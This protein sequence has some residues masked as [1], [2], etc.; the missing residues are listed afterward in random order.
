MSMTLF[1]IGSM[2]RLA[3]LLG[4]SKTHLRE[5]A[6]AAPNLYRHAELVHPYKDP[7][8]IRVPMPDL[9]FI[10]RRIL[11]RVFVDF[12]PHECS[13][14]GVKGRTA[15]DN[16]NNHLNKL[17]V[18][19]IDIR[20]FYPN[21]HHCWVQDF[22]E[23]RLGCIPPVASKLR[24]LLTL[25]SGLPQGTCTSPA[26][27][28]QLLRPLDTRL[29][30]ALSGRGIAYTRWVDDMTFSAAFSMRSY[31][32]LIDNILRPYGLRIH[33]KGEKAPVQFGPGE[34]PNVTG[35]AVG[36]GRVSVAQAYIESVRKELRMAWR[37]AEGHSAEPPPYR[38]ETYWGTIRYIRRF[39]KRQARGLMHI[40]ER[41]AWEKLSPLDLPSKRG[42]LV[43][44]ARHIS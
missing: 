36:G 18:M 3:N 27:A 12:Q 16:A 7:R 4:V 25:E 1:P 38:R 20:K 19:K 26:L 37:F 43:F 11:E 44:S 14:G 35:L 32:R 2:T 13:Y 28:D 21:V 17:F 30:N 34:Q 42:K 40:F 29:H 33:H 9:A 5:M 15:V 10:Q 31:V 24:R 23:N 22:F 41:V 8:P 39:S 6:E